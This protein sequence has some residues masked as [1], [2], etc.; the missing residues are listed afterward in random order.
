MRMIELSTVKGAAVWVNPAQVLYLGPPDGAG[1]SM[2]GDNNI[3]AGARLVFAQG[4]P[5]EV[6]E[7]LDDVVA[8]LNSA[9]EP[10]AI[11]DASSRRVL[12]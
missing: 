10:G 4:A 12:A 6:R 7:T 11:V 2:Y 9:L 3:R 8:R 5:L 1:S